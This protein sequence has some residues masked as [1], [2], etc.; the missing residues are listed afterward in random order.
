MESSAPA[1]E[2]GKAVFAEHACRDEPQPLDKPLDS[3]ELPSVG[4][5]GMDEEHAE[6]EE[7]SPRSIRM[8]QTTPPSWRW[9]PR[10]WHPRERTAWYPRRA[11]RACAETSWS[12]PST[13]I[14]ATRGS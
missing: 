1:K 13:S 12:T 11:C 7:C 6:L 9:L 5:E 3:F 10:W 2:E 4:H 8:R 14:P